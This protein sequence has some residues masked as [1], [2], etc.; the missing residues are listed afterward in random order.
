MTHLQHAASGFAHDREC[1][2]EQIVSRLA[3]GEPGAE[4]RGLV[5]QLAVA[6]NLVAG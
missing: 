3:V 1:L 6:E 2:R 5:A 4:L